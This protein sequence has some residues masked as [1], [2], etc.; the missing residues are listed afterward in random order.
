MLVTRS[1]KRGN[2]KELKVIALLLLAVLGCTTDQAKNTQTEIE[3]SDIELIVLGTVQDGG[4][5]HLGCTKTCCSDG[6]DPIKKV[7]SLGLVDR[8]DSSCYM[9]EASPDFTS[10]YADLM[11]MREGLSLEGIFLTHAHIGHYTGL[12]YLGREAYGTS[13]VPVYTM[14][15]MKTFLET[16][17]PWSQLVDLKNIDLYKLH[18]DSTIQ[19]GKSIHVRPIQVPHRDEFSET[20]GFVIQGP[21]KSIL[22]IP[23][24]DKW[25]KW[26]KDIIRE[27]GRVYIARIDAT[28][29]SGE[30]I[31]HRDIS[32]IP[33]PFV[34]ET[35][36]LFDSLSASER[37]KIHFI[38]LN[39]TNPLLDRSSAA[40]KVVIN[41]GYHVAQF[42]Q[43]IQL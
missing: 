4:S 2:P 33:H 35:M 27:V 24:I 25:S 9:F 16:N 19:L 14:P 8:S 31:N 5:P 1:L 36:A 22:F 42:H 32:E 17:G 43:R 37:N 28:F 39:H 10:Q 38:H 6:Y 26:D 7:V 11:A 3:S 21:N 34:I 13:K 15:K 30:E 12:M 29:Y 23:D 20:V 41:K 18:K 40:H